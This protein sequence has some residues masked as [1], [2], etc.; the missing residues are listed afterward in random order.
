MP[1]HVVTHRQIDP[2]V[3]NHQTSRKSCIDEM[4]LVVGV[5]ALVSDEMIL[6]GLDLA[7]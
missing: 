6:G 5:G 3:L 1:G 7:R 2:R 4:R